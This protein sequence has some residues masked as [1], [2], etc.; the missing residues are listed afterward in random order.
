MAVWVNTALLDKRAVWTAAFIEKWLGRT[1]Y[2]VR[3]DN[4]R[5]CKVHANQ[6][7]PRFN[8]SST[9]K[10]FDTN[11]N[12]DPPPQD[13]QDIPIVA[14]PVV[15]DLASPEAEVDAEVEIALTHED[16]PPVERRFPV[17]QQRPSNRYTPSPKK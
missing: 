9:P 10:E 7:R 13:A 12:L 17:Q 16:P 14:E 4:G 3:L 11:F 2:L 1:V 6:L 15:D 5:T 8:D